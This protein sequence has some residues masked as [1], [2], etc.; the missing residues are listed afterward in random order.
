M[1]T[2]EGKEDLLQIAR[3]QWHRRSQSPGSPSSGS[4]WCADGVCAAMIRH[5]SLMLDRGEGVWIKLKAAGTG[6]EVEQPVVRWY[7]N[8]S[9]VSDRGFL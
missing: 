7:N 1:S 2:F 8:N 4:W 6:K 3:L 9:T 5:S